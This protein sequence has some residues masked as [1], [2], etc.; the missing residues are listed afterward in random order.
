MKFVGSA[1]LNGDGLYIRS[2]VQGVP[3]ALLALLVDTGA[4]ISIIS[5]GFFR[6]MPES[7]KPELDSVN[8]AMLTATGEVS[9]FFG[10]GQFSLKVGE[11]DF[12]HEMWLADIKSDGILGMDF[13]MKHQCDVVLSEQCLKLK[14]SFIPCFKSKGEAM[15][16][17]V[18]I[19]V[20]T[21]VPANSEVIVRGK[22][23]DTKQ[24]SD[25]CNLLMASSVINVSGDGVP[26]RLMNLTD[27]DIRLHKTH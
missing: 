20:S 21:C 13:L 14:K 2:Y 4:N 15:C 22:V 12:S 24:F 1:W 25:C 10:K 5:V 11:M 6:N 3:I 23:I 9:P 18:V 8:I 17:R 27:Q 26:I 19:S 7:T 16:C